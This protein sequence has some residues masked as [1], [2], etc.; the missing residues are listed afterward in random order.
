[1]GKA[2]SLTASQQIFVGEYLIDRNA[3]RAYKVAFPQCELRY[4]PY[5]RSSATHKTLHSRRNSS[6]GRGPTETH[7]DPR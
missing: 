5:P 1:M 2:K 4:L 7:P 6:G 3:S